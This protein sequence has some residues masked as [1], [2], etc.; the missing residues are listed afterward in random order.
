MRS[1]SP[2][3][4]LEVARVNEQMHKHRCVEK[5]SAVTLLDFLFS[6]ADDGSKHLFLKI[7]DHFADCS[8]DCSSIIRKR[9]D[10]IWVAKNFLRTDSEA[11]KVKRS[12]AT[13]QGIAAGGRR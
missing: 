6:R 2:K 8:H 11:L 9:R 13:P 10:G 4:A 3:S 5:L 12:G 7:R 1:R